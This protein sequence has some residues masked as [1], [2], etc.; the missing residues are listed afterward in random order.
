MS[1]NNN[2]NLYDSFETNGIQLGEKFLWQ[3]LVQQTSTNLPL[4]KTKISSQY[5]RIYNNKKK[6]NQ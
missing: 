3:F 5:I 4:K 6:K 2:L 1:L